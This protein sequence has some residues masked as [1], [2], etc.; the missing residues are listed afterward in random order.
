VGLFK[1]LVK[2][3]FAQFIEG[4]KR[5]KLIVYLI[6]LKQR[7]EETLKDFIARFNKEKLVVDDQDESVVLR[8][9][10]GGIWLNGPLMQVVTWQTPTTLQQFTDKIDEHI[11]ANDTIMAF[12]K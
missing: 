4:R 8:A 3:F 7:E 11:N 6:T 1:D 10:L 2:Q 12:T 5:R 9:L